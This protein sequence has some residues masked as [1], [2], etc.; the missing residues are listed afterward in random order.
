MQHLSDHKGIPEHP[1]ASLLMLAATGVFP[2][3]DVTKYL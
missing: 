2:S 3:Y 1:A